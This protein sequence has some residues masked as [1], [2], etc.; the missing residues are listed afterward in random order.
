MKGDFTRDTFRKKKHYSSVRMQQGRV[1]LDSDWNEQVDIQAHLQR[2][3]A[4]D[5]IGRYGVPVHGAGLCPDVGPGF[6]IG[7]VPDTEGV[8]IGKLAGGEDLSISPGRI[9]VDGI[10]CE[11]ESKPTP[12]EIP[13]EIPSDILNFDIGSRRIGPGDKNKVVKVRVLSIDTVEFKDLKWVEISGEAKGLPKPKLQVERFIKEKSILILKGEIPSALRLDKA[14][15]LRRVVTYLTQPDYYPTT[16]TPGRYLLYLDVWQRHITCLEDPEILENALGGPDTTTRTKTIWQAKLEG[17]DSGENCDSFGPCWVPKEAVSTGMLAAQAKQSLGDVKPCELPAQGGYRSLENQLYRVEFHQYENKVPYF[18]WGRDNGSLVAKWVG[19]ASCNGVH[20]VTVS[21][22]GRDGILGFA[23]GQW[24][25]I[26]NDNQ[27]LLGKPGIIAL[28][29][30]VIGQDLIINDDKKIHYPDNISSL[31]N[32][33]F[34][35]VRRWDGFDIVR[36]P[37]EDTP[38]TTKDGWILLGDEGVEIKFDIT[39]TYQTGDYWLIPARAAPRDTESDGVIWPKDDLTGLPLFEYRHGIEHH[40]CPLAICV[41]KDPAKDKGSGWDRPKNCAPTFL[42]LTEIKIPDQQPPLQIQK[43]CCTFTVGKEADLTLED[44]FKKLETDKQISNAC[45]CLLPGD[46]PLGNVKIERAANEPLV[47]R[48][49]GCSNGSSINLRDNNQILMNGLKSVIMENLEIHGNGDYSNNIMVLL[50]GCGEVTLSS[51]QMS[52]SGRLG[53]MLEINSPNRLRIEKSILNSTY[54]LSQSL[55]D[56]TFSKSLNA[57]VAQK[58]FGNIDDLRTAAGLDVQYTQVGKPVLERARGFGEHLNQM[59]GE[60]LVSLGNVMIQSLDETVTELKSQGIKVSDQ[61]RRSYDRFVTHILAS[62]KVMTQTEALPVYAAEGAA[63]EAVVRLQDMKNENIF[64]HSRLLAGIFGSVSRSVPG[65]SLVLSGV[66]E[67]A[68]LEDNHIIGT[69]SLYDGLPM[70]EGQETKPS[71]GIF[72]VNLDSDPKIEKIDIAG[73]IK[74]SNLK[75]VMQ[76]HGNRITQIALGSSVMDKIIKNTNMP[77]I[78]SEKG[79]PLMEKQIDVGNVFHQ[80]F[81]TN[82]LIEKGYNQ[83]LAEHLSLISNRFDAASGVQATNK[84]PIAGFVTAI[85]SSAMYIGNSGNTKSEKIRLVSYSQITNSVAD[86]TN[87][88]NSIEIIEV[89]RPS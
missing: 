44:A 40:Y 36:L 80:I 75:S 35:K 47:L 33:S 89:Y 43:G 69:L 12:I 18:K 68:V 70:K 61:E 28:M 79:A 1:Q 77:K 27:E 84:T 2:E 49:K 56:G 67:E 73:L 53:R 41:L 34:S 57:S 52:Y 85:A 17:C 83:L 39:G 46:H 45:I 50:K 10:L 66:T 32:I 13:A 24:V 14:P 87:S 20:K 22:A 65:V 48:V 9:Y 37:A 25:E 21:D 86:T 63:K 76:V 55:F 31:D 51:C 58:A 7:I 71:S 3:E 26:T 8:P 54:S 82:N 59:T 64:T 81:M 29:A 62:G 38:S 72:K 42:P 88:L 11:F 5:V 6:S 30:D 60:E 16:P 19:T 4:I 23:K 74:F 78:T 15:Q